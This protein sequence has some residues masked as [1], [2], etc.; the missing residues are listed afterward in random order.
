MVPWPRASTS[1][2]R[3][4]ALSRTRCF[5][6]A[7]SGRQFCSP[8][9]TSFLSAPRRAWLS[10]YC[11][12]VVSPGVRRL[13]WFG[14]DMSQQ[15]SRTCIA[16]ANSVF[17][18]LIIVRHIRMH[19]WANGVFFIR[20]CCVSNQ[21]SVWLHHLLVQH[22]STFEPTSPHESALTEMMDARACESYSV[23]VLVDLFA[24]IVFTDLTRFRKGRWEE[25]ASLEKHWFAKQVF[26]AFCVCRKCTGRYCRTFVG[27]STK[28]RYFRR[29]KPHI[30]VCISAL[31]DSIGRTT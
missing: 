16:P 25:M 8:D 28:H 26:V 7:A 3:L 21:V 13:L 12:A 19:V 27:T 2:T 22:I 9:T 29:S 15:L 23:S 6:T 5:V 20:F 4:L 11:V 24:V 30:S 17:V 31:G 18:C 14:C 10:G 1:A